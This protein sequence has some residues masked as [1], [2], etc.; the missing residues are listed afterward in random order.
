MA[1]NESEDQLE[2][3][4]SLRAKLEATQAENRELAAQL[5]PLMA[6]RLI[7]DKGF[8]YLKPEDL[9]DVPLKELATKAEA[10]NKAKESVHATV[11][12]S[13]LADQ[14]VPDDELEAAV[15]RFLN[16]DKQETHAEASSRLADLGRIGGAIPETDKDKGLHGQARIEAALQEKYAKNRRR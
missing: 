1:D 9:A 3:G 7:A 5:K 13:I 16:P 10:L 2:T 12:K 14:G 6:E 11:V 8:K 15:Q 4:G